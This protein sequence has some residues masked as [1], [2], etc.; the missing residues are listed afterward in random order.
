MNNGLK[1]DRILEKEDAKLIKEFIDK[2]RKEL[3]ETN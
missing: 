2:I 1:K 3:N